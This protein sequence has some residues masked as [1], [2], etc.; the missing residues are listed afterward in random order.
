MDRVDVSN[1]GTSVSLLALQRI[2]KNEVG[3]LPG[4]VHASIYE[5]FGVYRVVP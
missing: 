1:V 4:T 2:Q 3:C 5:G